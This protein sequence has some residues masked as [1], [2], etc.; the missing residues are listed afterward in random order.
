M[1][2]KQVG[3][4][5]RSK[6]SAIIAVWSPVV[7]RT[8]PSRIF[9]GFRRA[10]SS[11]PIRDAAERFR[12]VVIENRPAIEVMRKHDGQDTLHYVDPPYI[13][14]TRVAKQGYGDFEMSE[15]DHRELL[16]CL[17]ELQGKVVLSGYAN[18]LYDGMLSGWRRVEREARTL[19]SKRMEVIWL[20]FD[21]VQ[22]AVDD[23]PG[24]SRLI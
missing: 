5:F 9:S 21:A 10:D 7:W 24:E 3:G 18:P 17:I 23:A 11:G 4:D 2:R 8:V 15:D 6:E 1:T 22:D 20:N 19:G 14:E 16:T 13:H 12:G